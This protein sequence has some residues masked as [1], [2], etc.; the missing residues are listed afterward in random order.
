MGRDL[1]RQSSVGCARLLTKAAS[2]STRSTEKS[3]MPP[4]TSLRRL[5]VGR[6]LIPL[7]LAR[8]T[9]FDPSAAGP[10]DLLHRVAYAYLWFPVLSEHCPLS[11]RPL[12]MLPGATFNGICCQH[13]VLRPCGC[14]PKCTPPPAGKAP[15]RLMPVNIHGH[16]SHLARRR[17]KKVSMPAL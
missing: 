1:W 4:S 11:L 9:V 17:H 13:V 2:S 14:D 10:P 6:C 3:C 8:R 5:A 16:S 15:A 7:P 12:Q